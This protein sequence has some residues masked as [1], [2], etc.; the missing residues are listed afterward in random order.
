MPELANKIWVPGSHANSVDK[1]IADIQRKL[2]EYD[3]RL[4]FGRNEETGDWCIFVK[5]PPGAAVELWPAIG[6]RTEVPEPDEAM[7]RLIEADTLRIG[8]RFFDEAKA[9]ALRQA[10]ARSDA[11]SEGESI[12]AEGMESFMHRNGKTPYHRSLRKR[13]PKQ[14]SARSTWTISNR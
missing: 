10:K 6:F 14:R 9:E 11:A 13:D 2:T 1:R 3:E 12:A 7:R 5:M 8:D 4:V